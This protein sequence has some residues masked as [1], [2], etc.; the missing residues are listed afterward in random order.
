MEKMGEV[1]TTQEAC[2]FLKISRPTML[3]YFYSG[4]IAAQKISK[5]WRVYKGEL[6]R[7]LVG[8]KGHF[9]VQLKD[10]Y[11]LEAISKEERV[12]VKTDKLTRMVVQ[13]VKQLGPKVV[14]KIEEGDAWVKIS[15][16]EDGFTVLEIE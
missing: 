16:I 2:D 3:S 14:S 1:L 12:K 7:F 11:I 10:L 9:K 13:K 15:V 6:V 8:Q 5:G 4:K